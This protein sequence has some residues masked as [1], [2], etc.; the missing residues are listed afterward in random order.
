MK[1]RL[2][3]LTQEYV[4]Y[5]DTGR[6]SHAATYLL[7]KLGYKVSYLQKGVNQDLEL[8]RQLTN[9][10]GD[11]LLKEGRAQRVEDSGQ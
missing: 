5:C 9:N 3:D 11:Y 8:R 10:T 6:R 1:T 7:Q 2:L 4:L